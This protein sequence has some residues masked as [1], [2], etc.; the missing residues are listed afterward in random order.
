MI[1]RDV[2][3]AFRGW[4]DSSGRGYQTLI[5]AVLRATLGRYGQLPEAPARRLGAPR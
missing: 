4:A 2:I 5:N 3:E 1:D